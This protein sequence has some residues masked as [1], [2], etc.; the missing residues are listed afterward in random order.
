MFNQVSRNVY[1]YLEYLEFTERLVRSLNE[2]VKPCIAMTFEAM[3]E[4]RARMATEAAA[5]EYD[6][7]CSSTAHSDWSDNLRCKEANLIIFCIVKPKT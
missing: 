3:E 7:L 1:R 2:G 6:K 5:A 4:S